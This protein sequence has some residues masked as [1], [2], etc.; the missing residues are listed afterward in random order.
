[1]TAKELIEKLEKAPANAEISIEFDYDVNADEDCVVIC[2]L[3]AKG[4]DT[5]FMQ[6]KCEM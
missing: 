5:P 3:V 4:Y 2:R 6:D 1:M